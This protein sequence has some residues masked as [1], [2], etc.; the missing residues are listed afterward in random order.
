MATAAVISVP[1]K[2]LL[3]MVSAGAGALL[4]PFAEIVGWPTAIW[5]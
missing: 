3:Q 1:G 4:H 2:S 5:L